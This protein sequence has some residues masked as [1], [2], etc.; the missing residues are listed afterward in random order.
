MELSIGINIKA[1]RKE[2]D[3]TQ[4]QLAEIFGVSF[5]A[6]SKWERGE[7]YPDI[8]ML[9][10]IANYF[11]VSLDDLVGMERLR[12][13]DLRE[14]YLQRYTKC[15]NE[16]DMEACVTLLREALECFPNDD[17]FLGSLAAHLDN[18]GET[19]EECRRNLEES[20][21]ISERL[22]A[23]SK[24]PDTV[25]LVSANICVA[26]L[27]AGRR[28]EAVKRAKRLPDLFSCMEMNLPA[29][30]EGEER[31]AECGNTMAVLGWA[32]WN[33]VRS[34]CWCEQYTWEEKLALLQTA[35][36]FYDLIFDQGD[37][38]S[39]HYNA[40]TAYWFMAELCADNGA[41][42]RALPF[43][44]KMAYHAGELARLPEGYRHVSLAVRG[45]A[46]TLLGVYTG[47]EHLARG[48]Y[49]ARI[50]DDLCEEERYDPL[51]ESPEFQAVLASLMA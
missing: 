51:R 46:S 43:L 27:R 24:D 3:L 38:G 41:P 34:M 36:A 9:P 26:L 19:E 18:Y 7:G 4:E 49:A 21:A 16:G 32:V 5:Q 33:T 25:Q 23:T 1:L 11:G 40:A 14:D 13:D 28:E 30:L 29:L 42:E 15:S 44:Q 50:H 12:S 20:I 45:L 31:A 35:V 48:G 37:F 17:E 22:I 8:T 47:S 10:T 2:K 6:V 39:A